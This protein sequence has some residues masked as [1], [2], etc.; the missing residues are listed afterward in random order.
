MPSSPRKVYWLHPTF[1]EEVP[2]GTWQ[3][4][5][6]RTSRGYKSVWVH[7]HPAAPDQKLRGLLHGAALSQAHCLPYAVLG[8]RRFHG[9]LRLPLACASTGAVSERTLVG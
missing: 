9:S 8:V 6:L 2:L 3:C 1:P 4:Q 7:H 5:L